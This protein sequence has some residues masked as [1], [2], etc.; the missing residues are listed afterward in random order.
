MLYVEFLKSYHQKSQDRWNGPVSTQPLTLAMFHV[1]QL[2][3][4]IINLSLIEQ[5]VNH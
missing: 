3:F 1:P 4:C 5:G 2:N